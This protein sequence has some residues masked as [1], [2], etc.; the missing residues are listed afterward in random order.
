MILEI[1]SSSVSHQKFLLPLEKKL[2][3]GLKRALSLFQLQ[4]HLVTCDSNYYA[5]GL[6]RQVRK[7]T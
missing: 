7:P 5:N 3:L 2:R 6:K 4:F 1:N